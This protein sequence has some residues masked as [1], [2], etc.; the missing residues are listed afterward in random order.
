MCPRALAHSIVHHHGDWSIESSSIDTAI[1]TMA[2]RNNG[3]SLSL[4]GLFCRSALELLSTYYEC[5]MSWRER[6]DTVPAN[7][8]AKY[9]RIGKNALRILNFFNM[10]SNNAQSILSLFCLSVLVSRKVITYTTHHKHN[11]SRGT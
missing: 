3:E 5:V 2:N 11:L 1:T 6:D 8:N 4:G 9:F 10:Y 7:H